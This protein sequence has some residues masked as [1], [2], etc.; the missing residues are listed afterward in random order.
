MYCRYFHGRS[1]KDLVSIPD[2]IGVE[3]VFSAIFLLINNKKNKKISIH[4]MKELNE[5]ERCCKDECE[6]KNYEIKKR[7]WKRRKTK[8]K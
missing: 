3:P 4:L 7:R 1:S 8:Q 5:T 2:M 6:G